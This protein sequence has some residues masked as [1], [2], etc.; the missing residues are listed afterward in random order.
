MRSDCSGHLRVFVFTRQLGFP[1]FVKKLDQERG[2]TKLGGAF[3][4]QSVQKE[5]VGIWVDAGERFV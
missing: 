1:A 4:S 3:Q 2:K 5:M